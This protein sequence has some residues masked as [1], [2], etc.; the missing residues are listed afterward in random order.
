MFFI[1]PRPLR[2]MILTV[3]AALARGGG[4]GTQAD[5]VDKAVRKLMPSDVHRISFSMH[6][7]DERL[8][9]AAFIEREHEPKPGA[10]VNCGEMDS[11]KP[12]C[13]CF[14]PSAAPETASLDQ[15]GGAL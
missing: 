4:A 10:C 14:T 5:F 9:C 12:E 2:P 15:K 3:F 1:T 6:G 7:N 13:P 8:L 11:H